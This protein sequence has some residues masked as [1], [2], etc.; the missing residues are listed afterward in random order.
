MLLKS[1]EFPDIDEQG[2]PYQLPFFGKKMDFKTPITILVG[3]NGAGKS[4]LLKLMNDV[5]KLYRIDG[6]SNTVSKK[7][8]PLKSVMDQ[9]L[10][11]YYRTKPKG[12]FFSAE[13]F[14]TYIHGL[15]LNRQ[16]AKQAL[17]EIEVE[18]KNKSEFSKSLARMPHMS[19]LHDIDHLY[20]KDL[21]SSS[22]GEAYLDF[23]KSRLRKNELY[24]LDEPETPLSIQN[25]I[26]L[27]SILDEAIS[28]GN[29]FVIATHSPIIMAIPEATIYLIET[30]GISI[31]NY[32]EIE[33]VQLLKQF[34]NH[35]EQFFRHLYKKLDKGSQY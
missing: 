25:Q 12:F 27:L 20:Q 21:L 6:A 9:P 30:G 8:S 15:E 24:F 33:S 3:E 18:Y 5:V 31:V 7:G 14:T 11:T 22:H 16:D 28:L 19:T 10:V 26:T 13:D 32:D 17:D 1:V 34:L 2:Y 29:Q 23:F 4:S 35:K